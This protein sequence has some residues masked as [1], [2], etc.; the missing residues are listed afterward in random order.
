VF[1]SEEA[2]MELLASKLFALDSG[3]RY[4]AVN[5]RGAI[6][7]MEQRS[8]WPSRNPP[9][10]DR[11]EELLVNPLLLEATKRRGD[12]DLDGVRYVIIRYGSQYQAIFPFEAGHVSVGIEPGSDVDGIARRVG[13]SL[14][15]R[16]DFRRAEAEATREAQPLE[17]KPPPS[18]VSSFDL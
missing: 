4:V 18:I 6:V 15:G 5:Q 9:E 3:I 8:E 14:A 10:T 7:E 11:M 17:R 1:F 16:G 12:L 13:E 2:R